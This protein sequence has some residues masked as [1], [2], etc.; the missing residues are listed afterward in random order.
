[1]HAQRFVVMCKRKYGVVLV[2]RLGHLAGLMYVRRDVITH[3]NAART[4]NTQAVRH[5]KLHSSALIRRPPASRQEDITLFP[6]ESRRL[7]L[8]GR[9]I[10]HVTRRVMT[11]LVNLIHATGH[12]PVFTLKRNFGSERA[13]SRFETTDRHI[14]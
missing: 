2:Y 10:V 9:S 3:L 12:S 6:R 14:R 11:N 13:A 1:V 8:H 7:E 4:K 5:F